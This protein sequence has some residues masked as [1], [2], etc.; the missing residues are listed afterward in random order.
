MGAI[1]WGIGCDVWGRRWSFNITLFL[2]GVFGLASGGSGDFI[3]LASLFAVCGFGVG[4]NLPVDSAVFLGRC[5]PSTFLS[6]DWTDIHFGSRPCTG[7]PPVST[8]GHVWMVGSRATPWEFGKI[9]RPLRPFPKSLK[10]KQTG[11]LAINHKF[12]VPAQCRLVRSSRK[13]G[14][15]V[16]DVYPR[17]ADTP[18]V[19]CTLL[20]LQ[21]Q[22]EP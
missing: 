1:V 8:N 13:H 17:W 18:V 5:I 10:T 22:R 20:R 4:G 6:F 19:V 14:V 21:V 3:T 9:L 12:F 7:V 11:C 16:F 15:E 2:T